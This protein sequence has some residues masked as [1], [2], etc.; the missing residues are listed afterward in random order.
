MSSRIAGLCRGMVFITCGVATLFGCGS[1]SRGTL[2]ETLILELPDGTSVEV[3]QG[4]GAPSLANSEWQFFRNSSSGQA[5]AFLT[6][7]FG[8]DGN[9]ESFEENTIAREIFGDTIY[10]DGERH[11]TEQQGL[12]YA[13]ATFGAETADA[14][15]FAFEG[16]LSAFVAGFEAATATATATATYDADDPN[17]VFGAFTFS[18]RVLVAS[19]PGANMDDSFN[20]VGRRVTGE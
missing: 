1:G 14:S 18:T 8:S 17:T 3:E 12:Q 10:F 2:P 19:F 5:I 6:V 16:R 15:G 11:S 13:A 20:F 4:A 9:L 7:Y